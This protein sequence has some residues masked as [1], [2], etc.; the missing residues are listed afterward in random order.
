MENVDLNLV[1]DFDHLVAPPGNPGGRFLALIHFLTG[2]WDSATTTLN[3][4]NH[5]KH[6]MLV[7]LNYQFVVVLLEVIDPGFVIV[8]F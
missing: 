2:P 3:L 1:D 7:G 4:T 8:D 5:L 6:L